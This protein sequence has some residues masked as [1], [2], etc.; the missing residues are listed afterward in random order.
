MDADD[1]VIHPDDLDSFEETVKEQLA[2]GYTEWWGMGDV[3]LLIRTI[4]ALQ[5]EL[6]AERERADELLRAAR[7]ALPMLPGQSTAVEY[8]R[9]VV[10]EYGLPKQQEPDDDPTMH[11]T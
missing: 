9:Q 6:A 7:H 2:S 5:A 1:E 4:R 8:L 3:A 10:N 11:N